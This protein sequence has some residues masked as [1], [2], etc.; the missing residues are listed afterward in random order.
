MCDACFAYIISSVSGD[1]VN[2]MGIDKVFAFITRTDATTEEKMRALAEACAPKMQKAMEE[3][4]LSKNKL[5]QVLKY[6]NGKMYQCPWDITKYPTATA[7]VI[8]IVSDIGGPLVSA[9]GK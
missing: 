6:P 8:K 3:K 9:L 1:A 4:G 5:K 7:A 2:T